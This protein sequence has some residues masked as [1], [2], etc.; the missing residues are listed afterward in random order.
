MSFVVIISCLSIIANI[1]LVLAIIIFTESVK[2]KMNDVEDTINKQ[3]E[4]IVILSQML[5]KE[6]LKKQTER[7]IFEKIQ[8][9]I[10]DF[11][12]RFRMNVVDDEKPLDFPNDE[13]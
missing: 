3:S 2:N 9:S 7:M 13:K 10:R 5:R 4:L 12:N 11:N 1:A 8:S 6:D